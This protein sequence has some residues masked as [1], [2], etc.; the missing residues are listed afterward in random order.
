MHELQSSS[1]EADIDTTKH[2]LPPTP[3]SWACLVFISRLILGSQALCGKQPWMAG[4]S[5]T[6]WQSKN[7]STPSSR[8]RAPRVR[9]SE[10]W[11]K[12]GMQL[13]LPRGRLWD[14]FLGPPGGP[15]IRAQLIGSRLLGPDQLRPPGG[16]EIGPA[17]R[18]AF[19]YLLAGPSA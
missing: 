12:S 1:P 19:L 9:A 3:V 2:W 13:G 5:L 15:A 10:Q 11:I 8:G 6:V 16:P 4:L 17:L 14:Q 7:G 18:T